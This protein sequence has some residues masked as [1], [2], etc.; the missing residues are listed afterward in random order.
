MYIQLFKKKIFF[1]KYLLAIVRHQ[2]FYSIVFKKK[3][4]VGRFL[5]I[6]SIFL[7]RETLVSVFLYIKTVFLI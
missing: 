4:I 5:A 1:R 3:V 2:Y 6:L 7:R